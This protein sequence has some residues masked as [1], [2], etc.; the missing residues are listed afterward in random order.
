MSKIKGIT[1]ILIN[2]IENGRDEFGHPIY[3]EKREQVEN[4][5]VAPASTEDKA[6]ALNLIGKKAVYT[7]AIPKGDTH[8][9]KDQKVEFFGESWQIIGFPK[10]GIEDNI[11]LE[12]NEQWMV[13]AYE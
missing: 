10:R 6:D 7:I 3:K 11:P 4:V 12:W 8:I 2:L 5:L 9:W 1:I 13:A